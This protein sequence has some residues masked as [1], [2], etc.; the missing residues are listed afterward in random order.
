L[1][2]AA[3]VLLKKPVLAEGELAI[4]VAVAGLAE[5]VPFAV[6]LALSAAAPAVEPGTAALAE[7]D[8]GDETPTFGAREESVKSS[9]KIDAVF[10]VDLPA[11]GRVVNRGGGLAC[12]NTGWLIEWT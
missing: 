8:A 11:D 9:L 7:A 3:T 12:C 5:A 1:I 4:V 10:A 6:V 2:C